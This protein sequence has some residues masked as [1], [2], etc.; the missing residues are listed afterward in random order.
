MSKYTL[1]LLDTVGI[2]TYIF[3]SN[4][5]RENIGASE[6]VQRAT[7]LWPFQIARDLGATNV[8]PGDLTGELTDLNDARHIEDGGLDAEIIYAGGG[9]CA[10]LFADKD[11]ARAFV[12]ALS[13]TVLEEAPGLDVV[14]AHVDEVD[15][16]SDVLVH[17]VQAA[18][19]A[20]GEKKAR[21]R[22]SMPL[23]GQATTAA[24][25]STG[26]PAVG[27][28][29]DKPG[30]K[31]AEEPP[32]LLAADILAKLRYVEKANR[33]LG[34]YLRHFRDAGLEIPYDF[35]NFGRAAGDISYIAVVHADGN[36]MG[37]RVGQLARDFAAV[38]KNRAYIL[39]LRNF[40]RAVEAIAQQALGD[41]SALLLRHWDTRKNAIVGQGVVRDEGLV[42]V[43]GPIALARGE[44]WLY[45]PFRPLVFGGDDLT[46]VTDG[47]LGLSLAAAYLAAFEKAVADH[48]TAAVAAKTGIEPYLAGLKAC[49]GVS[50]V[51]T[52]YPFS[53]AYALAED[54]CGNAK[55]AFDRQVSALDWHFAATG[56]F[57]DLDAIRARHYTVKAGH[58]HLRPVRLPADGVTWRTWPGF[59]AVTKT[60]AM[61]AEWRD[62][63]NKV[64]ALR[65]ALR[66]GPEAVKRFRTIY[67]LKELP[68]WPGGPPPLQESGWD[69]DRCG[70]FDAVEALDFFV[71]LEA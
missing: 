47:R 54:L 5:L 70:Y 56:L 19:R 50:V 22:T 26:L 14:A 13:R 66:D 21:R 58:L 49:A 8:N 16:H 59:T 61:H 64:V 40:S 52:H 63:H 1:T 71:P 9:N 57:G 37:Q 51:K 55:R 34:D 45:I 32:R 25:Q 24:C 11:K 67:Q 60:L 44:K 17:Q 15:L 36:G 31:P 53:A 30:L 18:L 39:A 12:T 23:L 41:I 68:A 28:D 2:Q 46:F 6:L 27:T 48:C 42:P 3:N 62:K 29:A 4:V 69:V 20:L 7:R 35:D 33:R 10:L 38:D 65:Q 43:G